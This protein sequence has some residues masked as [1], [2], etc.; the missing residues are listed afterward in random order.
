MSHIHNIPPL[1]Y[2]MGASGVGKDSVISLCIN[3]AKSQ[4]IALQNAQRIITRPT[5]EGDQAHIPC[6]ETE[7]AE[8]IKQDTL[9]FYWHANGYHYGIPRAVLTN[10]PPHTALIING[11][12]AYAQTALQR[13]PNLK[14]IEICADPKVVEQRLRERNRE[15][16][17][18]IH[19]RLQ[20][21]NQLSNQLQNTVHKRV[22]NN[23]TLEI[24]ANNMLNFMHSE[25]K[26]I[27]K[28]T[29]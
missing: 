22:Q 15:N 29:K 7:F 6:T 28:P 13:Y 21:S 19:A 27:D 17:S 23:S 20:R 9:L 1:F 8:L 18:Q 26:Q 5:K 24:A 12:R 14:I 25:L 2:I 3:L 16:E 10:I 11:S 4:G